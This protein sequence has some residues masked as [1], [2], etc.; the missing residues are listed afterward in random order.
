MLLRDLKGF[1]QQY[2][3]KE[4]HPIPHNAVMLVGEISSN[5]GMLPNGY[6][7]VIALGINLLG[8]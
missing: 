3:E 7:G 5:S 6:Q 1:R 4:Q 2:I 8:G